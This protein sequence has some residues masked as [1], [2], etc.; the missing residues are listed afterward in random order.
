[1]KSII[2]AVYENPNIVIQIKRAYG[3]ARYVHDEEKG[4]TKIGPFRFRRLGGYDGKPW[5]NVLVDEEN[6]EEFVSP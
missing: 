1:M 5:E 2:D 4:D 3:H 6:I